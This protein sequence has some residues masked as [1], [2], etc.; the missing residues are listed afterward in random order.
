MKRTLGATAVAVA[1]LALA[2]AAL[3]KEIK[4]AQVCGSDG[5]AAVDDSSDR[6]VLVNGG[7][8]RTPPTAAPFYVVRLT[9]DE[10]NGHSFRIRNEAVPL[11]RAL[12]GDDGTWMEMPE[13]MYRLIARKTAHHRAYPASSLVGA[14]PARPE[15]RE[16]AVAD[17][18]GLWPEGVVFALVLAAAGML[19]L[20]AAR[21]MGRFRGAWR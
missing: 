16:A 20:A 3:A 11:Q 18:N 17:D 9:V 1:A 6:E 5:C 12:R 4:Q 21:K 15:R 13:S 2:P 10:G 19:G 7:P 14:A 8:P